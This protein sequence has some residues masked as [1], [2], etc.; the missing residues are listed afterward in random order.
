MTLLQN[1]PR[2]TLHNK[3]LFKPR[4]TFSLIHDGAV[5]PSDRHQLN[6]DSDTCQGRA[7]VAPHQH[8]IFWHRRDGLHK[9]CRIPLPLGTIEVPSKYLVDVT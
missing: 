3:P 9:P 7:Q 1:P 8:I 6:K 4:R 5:V 2:T